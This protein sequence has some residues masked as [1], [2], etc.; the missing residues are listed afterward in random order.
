MA[1]TVK[2]LALLIS[3]LLIMFGLTWSLPTA[4]AADTVAFQPRFTSNVNGAIVAIGN[5]LL[6]CPEEAGGLTTPEWAEHCQS[7]KGGVH[8]DDNSFIMKPLDADG[9]AFPTSSSSMSELNLPL[10]AKVLWAGLYWGA[11]LAPGE[12][13][14]AGVGDPGKMS[15]RPPGATAYQTIQ[16]STVFGPNGASSG[17]Y[18]GFADVT[19]AVAKAGRGQYWA[20]DIVTGTGKD[21]YAGWS[22]LVAYS[23]PSLPLRNL[24]VFDGFAMVAGGQPQKITLSGFTAPLDGPV[25]TSLS[26]VA[27]EGDLTQ[28]GDYVNLND[29]QLATAISPGS[30]FFNSTNDWMGQSVTSRTPADRNMLGFD[31]KNLT[32]SGAIGNGDSQAVLTFDS[33]GDT[34]YPGVLATAINLY[35]PDFTAS[36]KTVHNLN[37]SDLVRPGDTLVYTV[38]YVNS[39]QDGAISVVSHDQ[40]PAGVSYLPG[41]LELVSGPG[42]SA[43]RALT[44]SAGDDVGEVTGGQVI[45]R[46]GV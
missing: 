8:Y 46:R 31:V 36:S 16:A 38:D 29:S 18:Q 22:L 4:Q 7:A 21:R 19:A 3:L 26:M 27:Y 11:R 15:L 14:T 34:Y 6:T 42:V 13:G 33:T 28:S 25:D 44:D 24:T 45:V 43:G 40:L 32:V 41:S 39:G 1:R 35:S 2:T 37:G 30:N 23:A 17:A 12:G 20:G 5:A 9:D 10:G